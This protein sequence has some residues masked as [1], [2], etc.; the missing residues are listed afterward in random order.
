[1]K[2]FILRQEDFSDLGMWD[3]LLDTLELD[4]CL[5]YEVAIYIRSAEGITEDDYP[6][7]VKVY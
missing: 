7:G 4:K 2:S 6:T 5:T 1:M 3:D